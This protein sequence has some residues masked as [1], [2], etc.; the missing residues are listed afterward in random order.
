MYGRKMRRGIAVSRLHLLAIHFLTNLHWGRSF[1]S[2][3]ICTPREETKRES[4]EA[5]ADYKSY[6]HAD[7]RESRVVS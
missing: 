3:E 6:S 7:G 2:L 4:Y 5:R 1:V